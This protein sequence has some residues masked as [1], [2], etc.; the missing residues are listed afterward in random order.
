V[1]RFPP[2]VEPVFRA[3]AADRPAVLVRDSAYLNWRHVQRPGERSELALGRVQGELRGYVVLRAGMLVDWLVPPGE[4]GLA[5]ALLSWAVERVRAAG[6]EELSIVVPDT[7]P[8][9]LLLQELGF[10]A[11]GFP[12]YLCFR[13]FQR[14][15]IMSWL[16][17]HWYYTRGDVE[18]EV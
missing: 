2:E 7:A 16:F 10:R 14:P 3:F 13:S 9:W 4:R 18:R 17:K 11:Q 8:E 5:G 15:A 12:E 1:P 6:R